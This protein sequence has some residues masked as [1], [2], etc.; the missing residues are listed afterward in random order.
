[1]GDYQFDIS[2]ELIKDIEEFVLI[3]TQKSAKRG[4]W[5]TKNSIL[6]IYFINLEI[7]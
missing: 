4:I 5:K 2:K 6:V 3:N 1:M 7:R